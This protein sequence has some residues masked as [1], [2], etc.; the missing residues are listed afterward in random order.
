MMSQ[1]RTNRRTSRSDD[2]D[3]SGPWSILPIA[4]TVVGGGSSTATQLGMPFILS[5]IEELLV[6]TEE[7]TG[8]VISRNNRFWQ[9]YVS[10]TETGINCTIL[11]GAVKEEVQRLRD[12]ITR[13]T[14]LTRQQI[15]R[16]VGVDRRSLSAWVKGVT[17]PSADKLER[18]R[19]LAA[20]VQDIEAT[21]KGRA[22]EILLSRTEDRDLLDHIA[23]GHLRYVNDWQLLQGTLSRT[24]VSRR[25]TKRPLHQNALE[26]FHRGELHPLGRATTIHRESDYEQDLA[27]ADRI[28]PDEPIRKSRRGYQ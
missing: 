18:L 16:G 26:A 19:M 15:A 25:P 4:D 10:S 14:R 13:R 20:V 24:I 7:I 27:K 5:D 17:T 11:P 22:A 1:L 9:M 12:D 28:M 21:G 8:T 23:A 6:S 3:V 2:P